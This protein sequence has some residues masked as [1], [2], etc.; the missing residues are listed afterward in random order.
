[1]AGQSSSGE[2]AFYRR[3]SDRWFPG[4][5]RPELLTSNID[6]RI[7][8]TRIEYIFQEL[9]NNS[10]HFPV[11]LLTMD[12]LFP[13]EN[14][15]PF[16]LHF[17][18]LLFA[19]VTQATVL[20]TAE[21]RKQSIPLLGNLIAPTIWF[22]FTSFYYET[23]YIF[24]ESL[25]GIFLGYS[26]IIGSCQEIRFRASNVRVKHFSILF[27]NIFRAGILLVMFMEAHAKYENSTYT[28]GDFAS[29]PYHLYIIVIIPLFGMMAGMA[30]INAYRYMTIL[31]HTAVELKK[32]SEWLL[33]PDLLKKT[34][35]NPTA[36]N[37]RTAER[38][39]V[40]LDIRG[41]TQWSNNSTPQEVVTLVNEFFQSAEDVMRGS[42][43]IKVEL[44]GDEILAVFYKPDT[45]VWMA[46]EIARAVNTLLAKKN[47]SIGVGIHTGSLIEGLV[48]GRNL[49]KYSVMG[50]TVNTG[51]R[52]CD[53]AKPE[54]ILIS[55]STR[56]SLNGRIVLGEMREVELKGKN[57]IFRV[58]PLL[59][60]KEI[61]SGSKEDLSLLL[62]TT[63]ASEALP[64]E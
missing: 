3:E 31:R 27:E 2:K 46:L 51:K 37:L 4:L 5:W 12:Y 23:S 11:A 7:A 22:V 13:L 50:D 32:Y 48:G 9:I 1:M 58:H 52:I 26:L 60:L 44:T 57:E 10:A 45:A 54:E 47:L 14:G 19:S 29:K 16:L 42:N 38:T 39:V 25:F 36:L 21:F 53:V 15:P 28:L 62:Y 43:V 63:P 24:Q 8:G 41:F 64:A 40:F 59:G 34:V 55:E 56:K 6:T 18:L 20:G 33:G 49:K 35:H 17:L 30:S 61:D